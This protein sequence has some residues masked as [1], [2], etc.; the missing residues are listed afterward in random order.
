MPPVIHYRPVTDNDDLLTAAH[1]ESRIW[2]W[3]ERFASPTN[4][5]RVTALKGG[6]VLCAY[7]RDRDDDMV[8]MSW[9]FPVRTEDGVWALWSHVAGFLPEYRRYGFGRRLKFLQREWAMQAG[10][11]QMRWTFDPMQAANANFNLNLLGA[12]ISKISANLYGVYDDTLNPGLPTDRFEAVWVLDDPRVAAL[13]MGETVEHLP[14]PSVT[15]LAYDPDA[16]TFQ[17]LDELPQAGAVRVEL[18]AQFS[19]L[20][21]ERPSRARAW[22]THLR[23]VLSGLFAAGWHTRHCLR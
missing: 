11:A 22:Q 16:D 8:G 19:M 2:G 1:L 23:E 4:V 15:A 13:A 21:R 12:Q 17:R 6:L 20:G 9:A 18:P 3:D 7:D 5:M 14:M 10:Y